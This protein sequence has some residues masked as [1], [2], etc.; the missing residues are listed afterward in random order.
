MN[1]A[2]FI[3]IA[4]LLAVA[5]ARAQMPARSQAFC[6]VPPVD[7]T[8][9]RGQAARDNLWPGFGTGSLRQADMTAFYAYRTADIVGIALD[10]KSVV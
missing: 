9:T 5:P 2:L 3:L 6:P 4:L 8:L 7:S 10:R 1:R